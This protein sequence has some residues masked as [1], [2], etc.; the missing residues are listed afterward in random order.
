M[1]LQ[2]TIVRARPAYEGSIQSAAFSAN[3]SSSPRNWRYTSNETCSPAKPQR[4]NE[5]AYPAGASAL[6]VMDMAGNDHEWCETEHLGRCYDGQPEPAVNAA[7]R[8]SLLPWWSSGRSLVLSAP[9]VTLRPI[10]FK[11]NRPRRISM[12][13]YR[14]RSCRLERMFV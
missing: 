3:M 10:R 1:K 11:P 13:S 2:P 4:C 6:G 7:S 8:N 9:V 5:F 14:V 12:R